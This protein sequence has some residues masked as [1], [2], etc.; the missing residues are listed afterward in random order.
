MTILDIPIFSRTRRNHGL[1]HATL[2]ILAGRFPYRSLA[3]YS[4]PAGYF[5]FGD[6]PTEDLH[7]A[8]QQA[9]ARL[10]NGET[11][12]AIHANCGTNFAVSGLIAGLLAWLGL[13]GADT[14]R[15]RVRRLPL[16]ITLAALGCII[17]QPVGPLVQ[18]RI[19]TCADPG[20]LA[21]VEIRPF[22]FG[23]LNIHRVITQDR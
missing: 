15:E 16:A 13:A 21:V 3:G 9:H 12:L 18:S 4:T 5:I 14:R 1:E 8:V 10:C 7:D 2:T 22:S 6:V 11:H 20:S 23:R 17:S 19:T